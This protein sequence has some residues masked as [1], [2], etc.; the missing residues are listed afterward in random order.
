MINTL[1]K[2][3]VNGIILN[4]LWL[5]TVFP[6]IYLIYNLFFIE[7]SQVFF[8]NFATI[9]VLIPLTVFP[10]TIAILAVVR[11]WFIHGQD[12]VPIRLYFKY[13]R[14][15]YRKSLLLGMLFSFLITSQAS[16]LWLGLSKDIILLTIGAIVLL[17]FLIAILIFSLAFSVDQHLTIPTLVKNAILLTLAKPIHAVTLVLTNTILIYLGLQYAMFVAPF[18]LATACSIFSFYYFKQ[19]ARFV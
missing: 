8:I 1:L 16:S 12:I 15:N 2:W 13:V 3:I 14:E 4:V 7:N 19:L 5:L 10:A 6:V 9:L 11:N 17:L 18:V